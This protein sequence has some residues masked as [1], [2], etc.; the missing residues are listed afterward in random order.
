[1]TQKN[2]NAHYNYVNIL[3]KKLSSPE[4]EMDRFATRTTSKICEKL[5]FP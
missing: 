3:K 1:M 2:I 5:V 4:G